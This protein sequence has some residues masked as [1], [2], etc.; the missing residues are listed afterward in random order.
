MARADESARERDKSGA[1]LEYDSIEHE[2][3]SL[4]EHLGARRLAI[5]GIER[6]LTPEAGSLLASLRER[7]RE[8]WDH[9]AKVISPDMLRREDLQPMCVAVSDDL[10]V[11]G[12][13]LDLEKV[14]LPAWTDEHDT[15][16][17][18]VSAQQQLAQATRRHEELQTK[19]EQA[20]ARYENTVRRLNDAAAAVALAERNRVMTGN[21]LARAKAELASAR[22]AE[23]DRLDREC[24]RLERELAAKEGETAAYNQTADSEQRTILSRFEK[25]AWDLSN[26]SRMQREN[27]D[28][29]RRGIGETREKAERSLDAQAR[30][31]VSP[32]K[33]LRD[34]RMRSSV[35]MAATSS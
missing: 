24:R 19:R 1:R 16:A 5:A 31:A 25:E 13:S 33:A 12:W 32:R 29:E 15:R 2:L 20:S 34:R 27:F 7:P 9:L 23:R 8:E 17:R 18:L 22:D 26:R 28:A 21:A 4:A 14:A 10:S 3:A 30:G 6:E 35:R 11:C